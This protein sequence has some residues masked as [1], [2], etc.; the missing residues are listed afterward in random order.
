MT[1]EPSQHPT[2]R[3]VSKPIST[4]FIDDDS[5]WLDLCVELLEAGPTAFEITTAA[6]IDGGQQAFAADDFELIVCDYW[7]DDGT[8]LDFLEEVRGQHPDLPFV[9]VTSRGDEA[10]AAEAI[11]RGVT[12]YVPKELIREDF[13]DPADS[14]FGSQL[15][16][17][18]RSFRNERALHRERQIKTTAMDLLTTMS[19]E[20]ELLLEFCKLLCTDHDYDGAWIGTVGAGGR[21]I[22]RAVYDCHDH[23]RELK[24]SP[25]RDA[26]P[27]DPAV[28]AVEN[29]TLSVSPS[30]GERT[31]EPW[32][33]GWEA[34]TDDAGF[35]AGVGIPLGDDRVQFGVLGVYTSDTPVR[36]TQTTFLREFARIISYNVRADGWT[37][38]L[39]SEQPVV[40]EIEIHAPNEP[41]VVFADRLPP[42]GSMAIQ[43][44]AE[45]SDG[46][47]LYTVSLTGIDATAIRESTDHNEHLDIDELTE[48]EAGHDSVFVAEPPTPESIA[49]EYGIQFEGIDIEGESRLLTGYL[50]TDSA[51][52]NL[53][54][55]LRSAF[56]TTTVITVRSP[57]NT[58]RTDTSTR[59]QLLEPLTNRQREV[60]SHAFQAGYFE[61]P[62]A[63]NA[64]EL[65]EQLGIARATFTQH[66]QSAQEKVFDSLLD[67]GEAR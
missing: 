48:T 16:Q 40:L 11:S 37:E 35:D 1:P 24:L 57:M 60:L 42:D 2:E 6:S 49:R 8:G 50:S 45:R 47:L 30:N 15:E 43:S 13:N 3:G 52:P 44:V 58:E 4:L 66:L 53:L 10:V 20:Q 61:Q 7:L 39:I 33:A 23:V 29:E 64:T 19:N 21:I 17:A 59:T 5:Q 12:D 27:A 41:L 32:S 54:A 38:S 34:M 67:G 51:V 18:V 9:L 56:K 28:R 63:T 22:P 46:T 14:A 65:A 36:V 55:D 25:D 26:L 31:G 62:P